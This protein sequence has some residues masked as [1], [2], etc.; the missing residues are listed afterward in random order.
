MGGGNVDMWHDCIYVHCTLV[1]LK[2]GNDTL[3]PNALFDHI[4]Y[5]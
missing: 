4:T 1:I 3:L 5:I 2:G